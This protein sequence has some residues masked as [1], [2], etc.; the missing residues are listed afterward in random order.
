MQAR[1]QRNTSIT[2]ILMLSKLLWTFPVEPVIQLV[3]LH[4][5]KF[6]VVGPCRS[7]RNDW[8]LLAS[9]IIIVGAELAVSFPA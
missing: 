9:V 1:F 4:G 2:I 7:L 5:I 3:T 8:L 6:I